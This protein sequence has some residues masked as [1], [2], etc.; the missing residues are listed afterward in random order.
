MLA[1][2]LMAARHVKCALPSMEEFINSMACALERLAYTRTDPRED[3][4][5]M[6]SALESM[7]HLL[8][9]LEPETTPE[10]YFEMESFGHFKECYYLS[11]H[12]VLKFCAER[13]P[14]YEEEKLLLDAFN[15]DFDALFCPSEYLE[16]PRHIESA[17]LEKDDDDQEV[18]DEDQGGWVDN[19][20]WHDNTVLT[21]ICIQ[22]RVRIHGDDEEGASEFGVTDYF[23]PSS[24]AALGISPEECRDPWKGLAGA[25]L[26]WVHNVVETYGLEVALGLSEFCLDYHVWDLHSENVGYT[27]AA[28]GT[29][30]KPIILD[31]MSR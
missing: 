25:C 31:W 7:T 15:N 30:E 9:D 6:V 24:A 28:A 8:N 13:N 10:K 26:P 20:E 18:Y 12:F 2:D 14:T 17:T 21:H 1:A 19:P 4:D 22:P 5:D 3:F 23:W 11:P 16:L 29:I 27:P